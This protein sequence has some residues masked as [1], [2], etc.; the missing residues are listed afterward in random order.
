MK[1]KQDQVM[2]LCTEHLSQ[3]QLALLLIDTKNK[4]LHVQIIVM[5][6]PRQGLRDLNEPLLGEG[7]CA[8]RREQPPW[9]F[10]L[11]VL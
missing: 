7:V 9:A 1:E 11:I 4:P 10:S 2:H 3:Q 8:T 5:G 6:V